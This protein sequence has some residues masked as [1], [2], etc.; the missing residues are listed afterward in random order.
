MGD[1]SCAKLLKQNQE[2]LSRIAFV[3]SFFEAG[4]G[5]L[6]VQELEE[7]YT[8][9]AGSLPK[10]ERDE[11]IAAVKH[12]A[13]E[14]CEDWWRS[15]GMDGILTDDELCAAH[16]VAYRQHV[17]Q[18]HATWRL[19][20]PRRPAKPSSSHSQLGAEEL[21]AYQAQG[22][23]SWR[24]GSTSKQQRLQKQAEELAEARKQHDGYPTLR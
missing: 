9:C 13:V 4:P 24:R 11:L 5:R 15:M 23:V 8:H 1:A 2:M 22:P 21:G 3:H 18:N 14:S 16:L 10:P 6:K 12:T 19:A 7:K 20:I 17:L